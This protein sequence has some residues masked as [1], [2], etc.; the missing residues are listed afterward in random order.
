MRVAISEWSFHRISELE[1]PICRF[2]H[3][4]RNRRVHDFFSVVSRVGDGHYWYLVLASLF[5]F[6]GAAALPVFKHVIVVGF[7]CHIL[8]R[9]LKNR[10]ARARPFAFAEEGFDL[11]VAPLDKYSFPSGHTLHAVTFTAVVTVYFPVLGW[12]LIPFS[13][14]VAASRVVLG[15]HYPTDV[16]AGAFL[17]CLLTYGSFLLV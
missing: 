12:I 11:T 10:T 7:V 2:C 14:F 1:L 17:G 13:L 3:Q 8:Y 16:L 5:L 6:Q 15:L 4:L 9:S